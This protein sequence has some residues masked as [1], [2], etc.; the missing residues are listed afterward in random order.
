[1][2][3][4]KTEAHRRN[5]TALKPQLRSEPMLEPRSPGPGPVLSLLLATSRETPLHS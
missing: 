2:I 3:I 4:E 5:V 1:M